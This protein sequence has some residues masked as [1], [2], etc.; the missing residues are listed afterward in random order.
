MTP[1]PAITSLQDV[2]DDTYLF[3]LDRQRET[4]DLTGSDG[5]HGDRYSA[6]YRTDMSGGTITFVGTEE[7]TVRAHFVGSAAPGPKSWLWG[8][9]NVNGFPE[10]LVARVRGVRDFGE[11][12]GIAELTAAE[13]PLTAEPITVARRFA[14][15]ASLIAGPLPF[16]TFDLENGTVLTFLLESPALE[17]V[18]PSAIRAGSVLPEAASEGAISNWS[19]ALRAYAR[20][21]GF[22]VAE[23]AGTL[24]LKAPNGDVEARLDGQGRLT[25]L[26][27]TAG[28]TPS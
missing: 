17:P 27:M 21:R 22:T 10:P 20:W 12:F 16:V 18:P 3:G 7:I 13:V 9:E 25:G 8:W 15:A 1:V 24:S 5:P 19:R 14:A 23:G 4:M 6:G 28:P 11:R 2:V 26:S